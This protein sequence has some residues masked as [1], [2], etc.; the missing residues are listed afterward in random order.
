MR[1]R[2][3][4]IPDGKGFAFLQGDGEK[5]DRFF[6]AGNVDAEFCPF[7]DL[8]VGDVVEFTP[9]VAGDLRLRAEDV[10][11]LAKAGSLEMSEPFI[12]GN[13]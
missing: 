7:D 5:A 10:Q 9:V 3:N 2:I 4:R 13:N 8:E 6:H 12:D 11:L 1:G